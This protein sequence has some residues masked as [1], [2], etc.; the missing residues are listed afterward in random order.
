MSE[1]SFVNRT[2]WTG[3]NL[4]VLR[5]INSECVDLIYLISSHLMG[6]RPMGWLIVRPKEEGLR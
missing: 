2:V 6:D 1:P 4:D 5:G 3:G